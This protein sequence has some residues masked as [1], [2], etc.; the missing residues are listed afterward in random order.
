MGLDD[1]GWQDAVA[2]MLEKVDDPNIMLNASPGVWETALFAAARE[3]DSD[4][5]RCLRKDDRV[6]PLLGNNVGF[7]PL[8]I[9]RRGGRYRAVAEFE[10]WL[11]VRAPLWDV[12]SERDARLELMY[13]TL[14]Q[15]PEALAALQADMLLRLV[16]DDV[17]LSELI[18]T[19]VPPFAPVGVTPLMAAVQAGRLNVVGVLKTSGR[20]DPTHG[21]A[22]GLTPLVV[23]TRLGWADMVHFVHNWCDEYVVHALVAIIF[24]HVKQ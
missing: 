3:G 10:D 21:N 12:T 17:S 19:V 11:S 23:A 6:N 24:N 14:Y 9:A 22:A 18:E 1:W 13:A 4:I 7:S 16:P 20:I 2:V 15:E 8:D 5:I